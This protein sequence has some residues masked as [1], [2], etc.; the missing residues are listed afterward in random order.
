MAD[1]GMRMPVARTEILV[2]PNTQDGASYT[3]AQI[4]SFIPRSFGLDAFDYDEAAKTVVIDHDMNRVLVDNKTSPAIFP[5][6]N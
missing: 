3:E 4:P 6:I 1:L 2:N 5:F